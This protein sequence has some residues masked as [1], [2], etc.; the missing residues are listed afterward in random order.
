MAPI[1]VKLN[2]EMQGKAVIHFVD[3]WK[4]Q[5][6][7]RDFPLRVIPTQFFFTADGEPYIPSENLNIRGLQTVNGFTYHEGGLTEAQMR[8]ILTDMGVK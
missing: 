2:E 7:A 5:N 4:N 3:V 1:L 6:A 8:A